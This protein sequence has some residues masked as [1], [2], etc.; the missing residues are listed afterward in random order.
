[1][2]KKI[3]ASILTR[4]ALLFLIA[5]IIASSI[6]YFFVYDYMIDQEIQQGDRFAGAAAHSVSEMIE[7][8]GLENIMEELNTDE[9]TRDEMHSIFRFLCRST[10][11]RYL[12]LYTINEDGYRQYII[13]AANTDEDDQRMQR[14][15]AFGTT[16]T[17]PLYR[18]EINVLNRIKDEDYELI[19][20]E[21]GWV[22]M[23]IVPMLDENGNIVAMIGADCGME[24]INADAM[25]DM[26]QVL[27]S[28]A[29]IIAVTCVIAL[30]L[31]RHSV[32]RPIVALSQRMRR[33]AADRKETGTPDKR[34]ILYEDEVTDIEEIFGT[35]TKDI[36]RYVSD[37]EALTEERIYNQTQLDVARKIQDGIVPRECSV[38]G[39]RFEINGCMRAA[40]EVGGDFYDL[41]RPDDR[42][43]CAVIGDSSGKGVSAALFMTTV[44]ASIRE[45][46]MAGR[47]LADTLNR[48]NRELCAS[49]PENMFAT[50]SA[51]MLDTET[52]IVTIANA[53]HEKPLILS[54]EPFYP[55][56]MS[57][58]ALGLFENS[59][60]DEQKIVLRDGDGIFLY[61]DGVT[62][63]I[64]TGRNPYGDER[65]REMVRAEY[66][67]DSR[68]YDTLALIRDTLASVDAFAEGGEQFDDITCLA[69]VYKG[70]ADAWRT[71]PPEL[72]SFGT[73]KELTISALGE[74]DRAIDIVLACEEIFT[75]IVNYSGADE[76][77]FAGRCI[78]DT[79]LAAFADNGTAFDPVTAEREMP[80]F[81]E[82]DRGGMG[83]MLARM[84]S[85][86]MV[87]SRID[88]YNILTMVFEAEMPEK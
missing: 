44:K 88:G 46:I 51:L 9:D 82:L 34:L 54:R 83:I 68:S 17:T 57:G 32:T 10:N 87:Y 55:D 50:V 66:S 18:A 8:Y 60:I 2:K 64:D 40:R 21:Y 12:Y 63:A 56:V 43:V 28:G 15:Y 38:T 47:G 81:E 59:Q 58:V 36:S 48:V 49:N 76:I 14:E 65:L 72:G 70:S 37:I 42:R 11:L 41:I 23:H 27:L 1:M 7:S 25:N 16:R 85:S 6:T 30:L 67:E 4:I 71:L 35:M 62:E 78:G 61:T 3:R 22:C 39:D 13:C 5:M 75:N 29:A 86:D 77:R 84:K 69:L 52:G 20:N 45:N 53:G 31:I 33:F 73:V 74:N 80:Q 26:W 19:D 79:W 24:R